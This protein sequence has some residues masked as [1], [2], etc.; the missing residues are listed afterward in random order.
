[1]NRAKIITTLIA[2]LSFVPAIALADV[3]IPLEQLPEA[4]R[5][6]AL[7]EVKGGTITDI[8]QE[9]EGGATVYEVEFIDQNIKY[10]LDIAADGTLLRRHRD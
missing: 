9:T 4:V 8:E 6:T 1:M 3:D 7:R 2:A 10:E 5:Q